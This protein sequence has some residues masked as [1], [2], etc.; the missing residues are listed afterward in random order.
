M[1][2]VIDCFKL[3]KGA[4][5]S[6]GIYNLSL[7]LVKNLVA[8][9]ESMEDETIKNSELIILGNQRNQMDFDM[10]GVK[11]LCVKN[12]D[13][14]NKLDCIIWELFAV[15]VACKKLKA[16]RVV[17]PRG[18]CALTHPV[19]DLVI[20]HDMIPF[21][22]H[23]HYPNYFNRLENRYIM[24]R[25][26]HSAKSCAR[27]ITVSEESK[28]E[29]VKYCKIKE[30][31]IKVI[32]NGLNEIT[33]EKEKDKEVIRPYIFAMTSTLPH[34]NAKGVFETY[35]EYCR[36]S[37]NPLDL[38][39]VGVD[40]TMGIAFSDEV[41]KKI[42]CY[43]YLP[44]NL[45]LHRMIRN[46][47]AFLFLS[48]VEGFGF[49]PIEAMQLG[50]PVICSNVSS[51]PEIVGDAAMKVNPFNKEEIAK[52]IEKMVSDKRISDHFV[53]MGKLKT[54]E[55]SCLATAQRYWRMIIA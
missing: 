37:K 25:L 40:D 15:S 31:K 36:I 28:K 14:L 30:D 13:P 23:E 3:V 54:K 19:K 45:D 50:V 11:F 39:V 38:V 9:K 16:D 51:L 33:T 5:K 2:I 55:Y 27:I 6:I 1:R 49:P 43:K 32:R 17:F 4:G 46:A 10:P 20:I 42:R 41:A 52:C 24:N 22:Y 21:Y 35:L 8:S 29:I 44:N 18:F 26:K 48:L 53:Q 47:K 12:Y 34:K 7:N